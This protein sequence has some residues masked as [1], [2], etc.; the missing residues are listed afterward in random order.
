MQLMPTVSV[1]MSAYN[2]E[3]FLREALDSILAQTF[4]DFELIVVDD[5]SVDRTLEIL[6]EYTDPRLR[7][8]QNRCNLG[9]GAAR[10]QG[11][12]VARGK[13]FAVQDADD[14]SVP[15]R[16]ALQVA[17]L[18]A[19]PDV[20]LIGSTAFYVHTSRTLA[21]TFPRIR[22][23]RYPA[24]VHNKAGERRAEFDTNWLDV[25]AD[26]LPMALFISPLSDLAI[27]WTLLLHCAL[28][29]T[30]IMFRRTLYE[31]LGGFSEK[32][33]HRYCEDYAMYSRFARYARLANLE[34]PLVTWHSHSASTSAQ[35][36]AKQLRQQEAVQQDNFCWIMGCKTVSLVTWSA[37]RKFVFPTNI[38]P[39]LTRGE[40]KELCAILPVVTSNFYNA[41]DLGCGE[42]V[43][44]H[45]RRILLAWAR[46]AV[47]LCYHPKKTVDII[48]RLKSG[49]LGIR[50][51]VHILVPAKATRGVE[52]R[53][54]ASWLH[55]GTNSSDAIESASSSEPSSTMTNS[56]SS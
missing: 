26:G 48:S 10:N 30:T 35:N 13:Y 42:E 4:E 51:L 33:A 52:R 14:A 21:E 47:G 34:S 43:V 50:L 53:L 12:R 9:A 28:C 55:N 20:G 11:L 1:I 41:Y 5:G 7:V 56:Q 38:T 46:H 19:H 3:A 39:P 6:A 37:W 29:N 27:A 8:I 2:A 45:R 24:S 25:S 49:F 23:F 54:V 15:D 18:D 40:V 22:D 32:P 36:D 44:R 16:L 31:R 17:Y